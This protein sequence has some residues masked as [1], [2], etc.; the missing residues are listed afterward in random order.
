MNLVYTWLQ[1]KPRIFAPPFDRQLVADLTTDERYTKTIAA[2][3]G[4]QKDNAYYKYGPSEVEATG[5]FFSPE[6]NQII[7]GVKVTEDYTYYVNDQVV[8]SESKSGT[9]VYR[10]LF[11][12]EDGRWKIAKTIR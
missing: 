1:A 9:Q 11:K 8:P 3:E 7:I 10:L 5:E 6:S 2:I 4:L 12:L